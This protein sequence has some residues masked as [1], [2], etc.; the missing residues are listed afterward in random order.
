MRPVRGIEGLA[1]RGDLL[2]F[3]STQGCYEPEENLRIYN[4]WFANAPRHLFRAVDRKYRITDAPLC[5]VGCSYGMNLFFS[6]PG[7][8]GI[9]IGPYAVAFARS[10]GFSIYELDVLND[11]LSNL[12]KVSSIWCSQVLEHVDSPHI[13]LRKLHGLLAQRGMIAI[14]VPTISPLSW[15]RCIPKLGR[16]FKGYRNSDHIN[17]FTP[18][19]LRFFCERAG[20][21]T[22]EVSAFYPILGV[23][24]VP[25]ANR[26][27]GTCVY[28]GRK[29]DDWEYPKSATR[30]VSG[31]LS[32]F[33]FRAEGM[34]EETNLE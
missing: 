13:F 8:Y 12:P 22:I 34:L 27:V 20:F 15:L 3:V 4:K 30:R 21:Q 14:S 16:Y 23:D 33:E 31:N 28:V 19:T 7:S 32:G 26:L 2:R 6:P 24:R 5:D 17:A 29:I 10:L 18:A 1:T 25:L 11:D 9:E